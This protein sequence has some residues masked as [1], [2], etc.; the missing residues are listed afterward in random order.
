MAAAIDQSIHALMMQTFI[1]SS[2]W[3]FVVISEQDFGYLLESREAWISYMDDV[4]GTDGQGQ[5]TAQGFIR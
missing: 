3:C 5:L 1:S 4:Y 2:V